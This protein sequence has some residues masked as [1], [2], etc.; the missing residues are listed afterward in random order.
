[1]AIYD[2]SDEKSTNYLYGCNPGDFA[3]LI[4]KD[5]LSFKK[6]S[7]KKLLKVLVRDENM[8]NTKRINAVLKAIKFT[9]KLMDEIKEKPFISN[10]SLKI[11][12]YWSLEDF[13]GIETLHDRSSEPV[14]NLIHNNDMD[15]QI[16]SVHDL[17]TVVPRNENGAIQYGEFEYGKRKTL[18]GFLD[19]HKCMAGNECLYDMFYNIYEIKLVRIM[20]NRK[21]EVLIKRVLSGN[22]KDNRYKKATLALIH[23]NGGTNPQY[24]IYLFKGRT[25]RRNKIGFS[26]FWIDTLNRLILKCANKTFM[27]RFYQNVYL[28]ER[29]SRIILKRMYRILI[30]TNQD[31]SAGSSIFNKYD[32]TWHMYEKFQKHINQVYVENKNTWPD[33]YLYP[34]W[35]RKE[36]SNEK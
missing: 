4:Y 17:F 5:A 2:D 26:K 22:N 21:A 34:S 29:V 18:Y 3:S 23:S 15:F 32:N 16:R 1:M 8:T 33:K 25:E 31:N 28:T 6:Q 13:N 24:E 36:L 11:P 12:N 35:Y 19:E 27:P 20:S 14:E 9:E 7:G 30:K 10:K